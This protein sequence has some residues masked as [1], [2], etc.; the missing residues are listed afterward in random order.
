EQRVLPNM[1]F[2]CPLIDLSGESR[3]A[4]EARIIE[5]VSAAQHEAFDLRQ[6][7]PFRCALFR[8]AAEEHVFLWVVHHLVWDGWCFDLLYRDLS[9][10]YAAERSG[11]PANLPPIERDYG[12]FCA[13]QRALLDSGKLDREVAAWKQR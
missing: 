8:L 3:G 13:W 5:V 11:Q 12:D 1:A 10:L 9:A 6:G 4:A 7:P 2:D